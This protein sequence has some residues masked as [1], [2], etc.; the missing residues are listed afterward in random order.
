MPFVGDIVPR[1][2]HDAETFTLPAVHALDLADLLDRLGCPSDPVL[3]T[4]GLTRAQ[5]SP[6]DARLTLPQFQRLNEEAIAVSKQPWIGLLLGMRM[7]VP[8][9]GFLGFAAMTAPNVRGALE[10]SA[11]YA[12]IRTNMVAL[13]LELGSATSALIVEERCELGSA[14]ETLLFA[15]MAGIW[16]IGE[17]LTGQKLNG[18]AD[19]AFPAPYYAAFAQHTPLRDSELVFDQPHNALR[20]PSAYLELPFSMAHASAFELASEQCELA[21]G[22]L[23]RAGLE[24]QVRDAL[25]RAGGGVCTVEE[26]ALKLGTSMRTLQRKLKAEGVSFSDIADDTQH[27]QACALLRDDKLSIEQVA[28]QV[29]YSDV[30]NF[31]RAFRRWTGTTPAS[32]RKS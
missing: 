16:R 3:D 8:A 30:S 28:E 15:L 27:R 12:P 13:R 29:G 17:A 20:F 7:R 18:R 19:F 26:V 22:A 2:S 14:R 9:H 23:D 6:A 5:L 11:R 31:T 24:R 32:F 1:N 10:L 21:L 4:C 25:L